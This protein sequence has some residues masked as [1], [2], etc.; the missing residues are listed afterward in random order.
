MSFRFNANKIKLT[1]IPS[2]YKN[3][4]K[5]RQKEMLQELRV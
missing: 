3:M 1:F 5:N 4:R 2:L